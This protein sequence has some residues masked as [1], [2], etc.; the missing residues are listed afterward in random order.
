ML[1]AQDM[2]EQQAP[3]PSNAG[4]PHSSADHTV[5]ALRR[6]LVGQTIADVERHLILD[7][8]SYCFGN[9]THAARILG[10]SIRTLRNKLNEYMEAGIP[11][12][13]PGQK[14]AIAS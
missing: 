7:T 10:I 6:I 8:L 3:A 5:E 13:E 11:V 4:L 1:S 2:P 9:R 12:P 14:P